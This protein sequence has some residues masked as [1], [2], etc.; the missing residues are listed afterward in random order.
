MATEASAREK[1]ASSWS[2]RPIS[3][4]KRK[5]RY[6]YEVDTVIIDTTGYFSNL[7]RT[8]ACQRVEEHFAESLLVIAI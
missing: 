2:T 5:P 4:L 1:K 8:L 6:N 3:S 7:N